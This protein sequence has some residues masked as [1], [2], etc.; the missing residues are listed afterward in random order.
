MSAP[1]Q[2]CCQ[3]TEKESSP[4][5]FLT[6]KSAIRQIISPPRERIATRTEL[7]NSSAPHFTATFIIVALR[8]ETSIHDAPRALSTSVAWL[9]RSGWGEPRRR[10]D[11]A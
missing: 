11:L 10:A 9:V 4:R 7:C 2:T 1:R 6:N 8:T 3:G 5:S